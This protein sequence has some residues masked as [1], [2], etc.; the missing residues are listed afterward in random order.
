MVNVAIVLLVTLSTEAGTEHESN[1]LLHK[2]PLGDCATSVH[3]I[4]D[5]QFHQ[6]YESGVTISGDLVWDLGRSFR[7]AGGAIEA[8]IPNAL[9]LSGSIDGVNW[10]DVWGVGFSR[11]LA[12]QRAEGLESNLR[13]LRVRRL[14]DAV[15]RITELQLFSPRT[16]TPIWLFA[17]CAAAVVASL[18]MLARRLESTLA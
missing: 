6:S 3:Q 14:G 9:L 18:L 1:V 2:L 15:P 7:V 12:V 8:D 16:T 11:G 5:G 10:Y 13:F 17:A 4:T